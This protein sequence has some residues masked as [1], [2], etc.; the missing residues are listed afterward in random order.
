VQPERILGLVWR[1]RRFG[2][3]DGSKGLVST[4]VTVLTISV[5]SFG[6]ARTTSISVPRSH[7]D[8][9]PDGEYNRSLPTRERA[10]KR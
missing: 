10:R 8:V 7:S 3:S 2:R 1:G 9:A 4:L 6:A 5:E